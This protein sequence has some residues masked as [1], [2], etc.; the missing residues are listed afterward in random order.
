MLSM[1]RGN[2]Q[3]DEPHINDAAELLKEVA[4]ELRI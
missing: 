4:V 2:N 3:I 1:A